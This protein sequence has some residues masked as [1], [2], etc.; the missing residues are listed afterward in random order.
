M[1]DA[2]IFIY[3]TGECLTKSAVEKFNLNLIPANTVVLSFKLTVGAVAITT[4]NMFTNE[5]IAHFRINDDRM[6]EYTYEYL[7]NF[8]YKSLG[9]T[10]SISSAINSKIVK[11]MPFILPSKEVIDDFHKQMSPIFAE[12]RNKSMSIHLLQKAR[13]AL[14]P[15]LM[16]GGVGL[17]LEEEAV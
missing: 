5:A 1:G 6:L 12:I 10:S 14:L 2:N 4:E 7:K 3:N 16:N 15:R 9:N 8:S 13:D 11:E 17:K